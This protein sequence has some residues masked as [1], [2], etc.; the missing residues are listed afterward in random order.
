[1]CVLCALLQFL[2]RKIRHKARRKRKSYTRTNLQ[3]KSWSQTLFVMCIFSMTCISFDLFVPFDI[4]FVSTINGDIAAVDAATGALRWSVKETPIVRSTFPT[5]SH[6]TFLPNPQDGSLYT[7]TEDGL[8]KLPFS[9]PALVH[10]APCRSKEGILYAGKKE[11]T[12]FGIDP[13]TGNITETLNFSPRDALCPAPSDAVQYIGKTEYHIALADVHN[14]S[15]RWNATYVEYSSYNWRDKSE[16]DTRY[17][18][19]CSDGLDTLGKICWH[20]NFSSTVVAVYELGTEGLKKMRMNVLGRKTLYNILFNSLAQPANSRFFV[21]SERAEKNKESVLPDLVLSSRFFL[22]LSRNSADDG[23]FTRIG[24]ILVNSSEIIGRGSDGT[25]IF[26]GKFDSR[27]IAVKRIVLDY[28]KLADREVNALRE[29]DTHPNVIRYFCMEADRQFC[30]IA[31]EL[32]CFTL[33]EFV[34]NKNMPMSCTLNVLH[35]LYETT[36]GLAWLHDFGMVHRDIKPSNVLF[37]APDKT[38]SV[39]AKISDFGLCKKVS[40]ASVT[41]SGFAGTL[42]WTAPEMMQDQEAVTFAADV[43]SLGCL[44]YYALSG[45]L[46]AFGDSNHRQVNIIIGHDEIDDTYT[47]TE[48]YKLTFLCAES[49]CL[50]KQMVSHSRTSRPSAKEILKHPVFWTSEKRLQFLQDVSDRIENEDIF[51][52]VVRNLERGS[53]VVTANDWRL[54]LCPALQ[55]DLRKFRTYRGRSLRDLLRAIRNKR[56]HYQELPEELRTAIGSIPDDFIAYF[57]DRFPNLIMH[58]YG[59]MSI[60]K[61]DSIL[62]RYY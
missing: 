45:G 60:C 8:K 50:I 16:A 32:C 31:L 43:F 59:A 27:N 37:S 40:Q 44:F 28:V 58:V 36:S 41:Q 47:L 35:A 38:G 48:L 13:K 10:A 20:R 39:R 22:S 62:A 12:W 57:T 21:P 26:A 51:S 2:G 17:F 53:S 34:E 18:S 56:H 14:V 3:A 4:L 42:G 52:P 25:V 30:Y 54:Q 6:F 9:I 23:V 49:R 55:E 5:E 29:T 19:S 7:L 1:M 61:T 33:E 11:D 15:N 24:K 46:H